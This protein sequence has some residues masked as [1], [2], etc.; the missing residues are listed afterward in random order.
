MCEVLDWIEK[1][2]IKTAVKN[3]HLQSWCLFFDP[4]QEIPQ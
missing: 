2:G 4:C 1:R 3:R